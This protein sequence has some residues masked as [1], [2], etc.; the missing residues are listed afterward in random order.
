[1]TTWEAITTAVGIAL[2]GE[3][4]RGRAELL[5]CWSATG[6]SEAGQRCVIAHYLADLQSDLADEVLWDQR[7]L[8]AYARIHD[9]ELAPVGIDDARGMAPSL[10]LNL[11]DGYLRQGR[12]A[13]AREHAAAGRT[14]A[15]RLPD[16]GYGRLIR[17]GLDRLSARVGQ[18]DSP[19]R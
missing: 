7:A 9:A 12:V 5:A 14:L 15:D 4:E 2:R 18:T 6:E 11:G 1:M 17:E 3:R 19:H 8:D 10:H 13:L 16:D